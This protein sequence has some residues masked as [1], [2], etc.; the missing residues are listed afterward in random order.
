MIP[1]IVLK[2]P[3]PIGISEPSKMQAMPSQPDVHNN[4]GFTL[5]EVMIVVVVAGI[6]AAI[7]YPSYMDYVRDGRRADGQ[8]ALLSAAERQAQYYLD[9]KIFTANMTDLG[10]AADPMSSPKK[11]YQIDAVVNASGQSFT[12]T[13]LRREA[14]VTDTDCGDLTI[15]NLSV[16]SAVNNTNS[17]PAKNCW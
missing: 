17:N 8:A 4:G 15:N 1:G 11:F 9:H 12:L 13:A 2:L 16:K 5:I 3:V 14:Q 10:Y 6:F 7:A